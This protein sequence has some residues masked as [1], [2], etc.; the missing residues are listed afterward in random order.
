MDRIVADRLTEDSASGLGPFRTSLEDIS[1]AALQFYQSGNND[2]LEGA[3]HRDRLFMTRY[4]LGCILRANSAGSLS[5]TEANL[6]SEARRRVVEVFGY[7]VC[8]SLLADALGIPYDRFEF[9]TGA[10]CRPDFEATVTEEELAAKGCTVASLAP[11]GFKVFLEVKARTGW[12]SFR[13]SGEGHG[14]LLN[15]AQKAGTVSPGVF[16]GALVG[17]DSSGSRATK[18]MLADPGQ[19]RPL[20]L[21]EQLDVV[22][23]RIAYQSYRVGLWVQLRK[24]LDWMKDLGLPS[25]VTDKSLVERVARR[26]EETLKQPGIWTRSV[27]QRLF[28][29]RL[30]CEAWELLGTR[31]DR[32]MTKQK[33]QMMLGTGDLGRLFFRGMDTRVD[34]LV[35]ARDRDG[36]LSYGVRGR[37]DVDLAGGSFFVEVPEIWTR[38]RRDYVRDSIESALDNW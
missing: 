30:F 5:V 18:V 2:V 20:P 35:T 32:H 14:L 11:D 12:K 6:H 19:M 17:L 33:A 16:V 38:E 7:G 1:S 37:S 4:D 21:D 27:G 25:P 26:Y 36:L 34:Y 3:W 15:L 22:L 24:T 13:S 10:G 31:G 28:N 29:G 23:R 9:I 8:V